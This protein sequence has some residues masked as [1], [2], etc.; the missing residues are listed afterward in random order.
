MPGING[1]RT[2]SD[3]GL[4][5]KIGKLT[6]DLEKAT[7]WT[8]YVRSNRILLLDHA[9]NMKSYLA[10]RGALSFRP[11]CK[12]YPHLA[13]QT[14]PVNLWQP[15]QLTVQSLVI[16]T[17]IGRNPFCAATGARPKRS[18]ESLELRNREC[19][20]R[21]NELQRLVLGHC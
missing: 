16:F 4:V 11:F 2:N 10:G 5:S 7:A 6:R 9:S 17:E 13:P 14:R 3:C 21:A 8:E 19:G 15:F 12:L 18:T 20:T 1:E